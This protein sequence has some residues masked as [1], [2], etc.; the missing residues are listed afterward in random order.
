MA[1]EE[2]TTKLIKAKKADPIDKPQSQ[3]LSE[4]KPEI[5]PES[6]KTK[7]DTSGTNCNLGPDATD[8]ERWTCAMPER[9]QTNYFGPSENVTTS[10][11]KVKGYA[12]RA[13]EYTYSESSAL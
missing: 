1:R 7:L 8:S 12:I 10:A 6:K 4:P 9:T 11:P 13:K 2:Q 5:K 3:T